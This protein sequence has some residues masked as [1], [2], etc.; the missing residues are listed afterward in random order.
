MDFFQFLSAQVSGAFV[1]GLGVL[2]FWV[3]F[4]GRCSCGVVPDILANVM[5]CQAFGFGLIKEDNAAQWYLMGRGE[6]V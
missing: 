1:A 4:L 5:Q 3:G 2:L 6:M